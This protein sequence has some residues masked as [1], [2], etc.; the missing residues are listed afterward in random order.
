MLN[1]LGPNLGAAP[2]TAGLPPAQPGTMPAAIPGIPGG[3]GPINPVMPSRPMAIS[4]SLAGAVNPA[5][6][7]GA[8][9]QPDESDPSALE[10]DTL[11]QQDGSVVLFLK[12]PDG[13]RGPAVKIISVKAPKQPSA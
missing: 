6:P 12:N 8:P 2:V 3:A 7:S 5:G 4:P 9:P 13:S 10:Y 1:Y 11:T